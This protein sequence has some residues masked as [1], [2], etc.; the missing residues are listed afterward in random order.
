[1]AMKADWRIA[2][3]AAAAA[4]LALGLAGPAAGAFGGLERLITPEN[5]RD[6]STALS[7]MSDQEEIAVGRQL[8]GELLGAAPLVADEAV[9]RYVNRV[10]RWVAA[11]SE[12]PDLPW[13]FGVINTASVNAFAAPGGYIVITRGLY[14]ML[15]NEAQLAGVLGHEIS[16]VVQR[17]HVNALRQSG[18]IAVF[19]RGAQS[20]VPA[21]KTLVGNL[22]VPHVSEWATKGLDRQSEYEAD[23]LG[24]VLAAR[25]GYSANGLVEV[26][27]KLQARGTSDAG[28]KLLYST[29]PLAKDRLDQVGEARVAALP[30]G[31]EPAITAISASAGPAL[32][33]PGSTPA[34]AR[35]LTA[36]S[37]PAQAPA[38]APARPSGGSG[39]GLPVDPGQLLRGIFGR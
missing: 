10:G 2:R 3:R 38:P 29:H 11:Q 30:Q 16:H 28:L 6:G 7:G 26:L 17:H 32:L 35:A 19:A 24:V 39:S 25:A 13:R 15:E 14:D 31:Q 23:R 12:R 8:A 1:M 21:G 22:L 36:D 20:Q 9:Q 33:G 37:E 27:K 18:A 4:C 5:I 34:G